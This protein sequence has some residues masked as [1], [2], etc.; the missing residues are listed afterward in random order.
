M[1]LKDK[2][3]RAVGGVS[4]EVDR[5]R[6]EIARLKETREAVMGGQR[7]LAEAE[8]MLDEALD[9]IAARFNPSA[10]AL[11][12][13]ETTVAD[14]VVGYGTTDTPTE[15]LVWLHRDALKAR[16]MSAMKDAAEPGA[17]TAE[18]RRERVAKID[19]QLFDLEQQ[20]ERL[21]EEAEE[22]GIEI[23]RRPDADPRAVL[24]WRG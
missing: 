3:A 2:I 19:A 23:T 14:F 1:S 24:A 18:D 13:P 22:A 15:M 8:A 20:E 16:F 21:I 4:S 7:S 5:I 9:R 12:N 10:T 6:G 17:V 11:L